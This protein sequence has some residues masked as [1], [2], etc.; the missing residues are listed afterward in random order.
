MAIGL[1]VFWSGGEKGI[2]VG[3]S[4]GRAHHHADPR[5]LWGLPSGGRT[6]AGGGEQTEALTLRGGW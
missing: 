2:F 5:G 4:G 6:L 1:F 3:G